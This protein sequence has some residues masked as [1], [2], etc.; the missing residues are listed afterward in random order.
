MPTPVLLAMLSIQPPIE[1]DDA[2]LRLAQSRLGTA[3]L[4]GE[5]YPGSP[6][7]LQRLLNY[8]PHNLTCTAHLP[9][10]INLL[11]ATGRATLMEFVRVAEGKLYGLVLHDQLAFAEHPQET[12]DAFRETDRLIAEVADSP[13]IFVEYAAGLEPDFYARLFDESRDLRK[14]SA[15]IDVGHVGIHVCRSAYQAQNPGEDVCALR[16]DS[17]E[18]PAKIEAVQ[19]AT[20]KAL[21]AVLGLINHLAKLKKP[22]H[23]HLHNG[24]PLSTLS[25]FGV[26]DHLSFLQQIDLPFSYQGGNLLKGIF[27]VS[28]LR[29]ITRTATNSASPQVTF[30]L[31]IHPMEGRTP[32]GENA[33]LF[34]HWRDKSNAERMNYWLDM[35]VD[36]AILVRDT[37]EQGTDKEHNAAEIDCA[38][39][40]RID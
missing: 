32:L 29:D 25:Q 23:F 9:R 39:G 27:G 18:L 16:P 5:L 36:N 13:W 40:K 4:G 8:R 24:H 22:L 10:N 34:S 3:G 2:L 33:P 19:Q 6:E 15:A 14:L 31:E 38:A 35:L 26:S 20:K 7:H 30:C 28:G 37:L 12:L 11:Q 21:P 1:G 17:P